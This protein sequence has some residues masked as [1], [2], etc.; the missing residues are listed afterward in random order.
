MNEKPITGIDH[1]S[2][3]VANT[4]KALEFYADLLELEVDSNRPELDYPGVWLNVGALQIHLLEVPNP[5]PVENRPQHGGHDRHL[6]LRVRSLD[7]I[8]K[9]LDQAGISYSVSRSGRK[10]LFCRD[11]DGNAIELIEKPCFDHQSIHQ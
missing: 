4:E 5:D 7:E 6:A 1:S 8:I 9:R 2:M 11:Y 3:V 10:A